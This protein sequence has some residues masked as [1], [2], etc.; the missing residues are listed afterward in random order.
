MECM[1]LYIHMYMYM[2]V[3][4]CVCMYVCSIMRTPVSSSQNVN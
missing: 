1:T 3:Y 4:G 2:H